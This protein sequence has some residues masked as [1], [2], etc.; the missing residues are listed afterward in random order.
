MGTADRQ[1]CCCQCLERKMHKYTDEERDF[2]K[3]YYFGHSYKE[4]RD[5]FNKRFG[6][7]ISVGQVKN[8]GRRYHLL[9][10]RTGRFEKGNV[11][12][13]KGVPMSAERYA[14][15]APTMFKKGERHGGNTPMPVGSEKVRDGYVMVKVGQP[16]IWRRKAHIV[17][18]QHNGP[19]PQGYIVTYKDGD[20]LNC[21]ADNLIVISRKVNNVM[22][23]LGLHKY[24]G[25]KK[26][27]AI[28]IAK[29]AMASG[30]AKNKRKGDTYGEQK[31]IDKDSR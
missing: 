11:P 30:A 17:W 3:S 25:E 4:I 9:T 10:G 15:C 2:M 1:A 26:Q 16:D 7:D 13:N 28:N 14:K 20:P 19:V 18:E 21:D 29:L 22:S 31:R 8:Y 27:V 24:T 12:A 6:A 23:K 5:E